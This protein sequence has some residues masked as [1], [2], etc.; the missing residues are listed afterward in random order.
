M[1]PSGAMPVNLGA[2]AGHRPSA[3][4]N[5]GRKLLKE[6]MV[7]AVSRAGDLLVGLL[8]A[9]QAAGQINLSLH[10]YE[11][12]LSSS[13]SLAGIGPIRPATRERMPAIGFVL[14][15]YRLFAS[16]HHLPSS[17]HLANL[18]QP[19]CRVCRFEPSFY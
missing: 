5:V 1:C 8:G 17:R 10:F 14:V 16:V 9:A 18:F 6:R 2:K 15:N 7:V 12:D 4:A 11:S 3:P 13:L 19:V